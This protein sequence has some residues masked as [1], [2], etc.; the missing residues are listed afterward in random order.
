MHNPLCR[1]EKNKQKNKKKK[2]KKQSI[3]LYKKKI[4]ESE[5]LHSAKLTRI[6]EQPNFFHTFQSTFER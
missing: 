2:K 6:K 4:Y 5:T 3:W 1:F